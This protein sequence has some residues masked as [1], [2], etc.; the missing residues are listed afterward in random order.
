MRGS[1]CSRRRLGRRHRLRGLPDAQRARGRILREQVRECGRAGAR[2]AD[3]EDGR[4]YGL[5]LD[6]GMA[7]QRVQ[8]AQPLHP[9]RQQAPAP[10]HAAEVRERGAGEV[11]QQDVETLAVA[12]VAEVREAGALARF[13][14]QLLGA[15]RSHV[16]LL[17]LRRGEFRERFGRATAFFWRLPR[18]VARETGPRRS[19]RTGMVDSRGP[20]AGFRSGERRSDLPGVAARGRRPP[21]SPRSCSA[22]PIYYKA[23]DAG[24]LGGSGPAL[25]ACR[26][27]ARATFEAA[28]PGQPRRRP[29][30]TCAG[31]SDPARR[32]RRPDR[33]G[34]LAVR[35]DLRRLRRHRQGRAHAARLAR[36]ARRAPALAGAF[37][38]ESKDAKKADEPKRLS[39]RS[40]AREKLLSSFAKAL[41]QGGGRLVHGPLRRETADEVDRIAD[42]LAALTSPPGISASRCRARSRRRTAPSSTPT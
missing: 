28:L 23:G 6:L 1:V 9:V 17:E 41:A 11:V 22:R 39:A 8:H 36:R 14:Q 37:G 20:D 12:R 42:E 3:H 21:A 38:A 13:G 26:A 10:H 19:G 15:K 5:P 29:A 31:S 27:A 25:V 2:Q 35:R 32:R 40:K 34:G 24:A 16:V 18:E 4:R 7:R 30:P 33:R